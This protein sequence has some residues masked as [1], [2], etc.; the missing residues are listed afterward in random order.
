MT[1]HSADYAPEPPEGGPVS[2]DELARRKGVRPVESADDLAQDGVFESDEE[3]DA[4]LAHVKA[5]RRAET[6]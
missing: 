1:T 4:F 6:T 3:L 2:L 5:T